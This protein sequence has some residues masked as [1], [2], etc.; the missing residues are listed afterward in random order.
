VLDAFIVLPVLFSLF[1]TNYFHFDSLFVRRETTKQT[2]ITVEFES[3][4][5]VM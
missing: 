1:I 2:I 3:E 5:Y 4:V